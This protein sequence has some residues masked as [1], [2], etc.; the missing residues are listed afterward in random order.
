[1]KDPSIYKL[2]TG[3]FEDL[4]EENYTPALGRNYNSKSKLPQDEGFIAFETSS[5]KQKYT[6]ELEKLKKFADYIQRMSL[7]EALVKYS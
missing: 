7:N 4:I 2:F 6:K 1:M 3:L 5:R